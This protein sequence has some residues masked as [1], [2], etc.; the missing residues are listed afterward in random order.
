MQALLS[1]VDSIDCLSLLQSM[2]PMSYDSSRLIDTA[3][4]GFAHVTA[5]HL[6]SLRAVHEAAVQAQFQVLPPLSSG[7]DWLSS[8]PANPSAAVVAFLSQTKA[9]ESA[10][11]FSVSAPRADTVLGPSSSHC[12]CPHAYHR[13]WASRQ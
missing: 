8:N 3:A 13:P 9:F 7:C 1:T 11:C 6:Q 10:I 2:A 4:I 12:Q 5:L